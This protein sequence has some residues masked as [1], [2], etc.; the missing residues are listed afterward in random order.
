MSAIIMF[1]QMRP[2]AAAPI[3][4]D[5]RRTLIKLTETIGD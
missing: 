1:L 3:V 5:V 2:T 4:N